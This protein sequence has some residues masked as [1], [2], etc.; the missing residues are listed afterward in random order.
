MKPGKREEKKLKEAQT[1]NKA[2]H[3]SKICRVPPVW[4]GGEDRKDSTA[5]FFFSRV[6]RVFRLNVGRLF[7][8]FFSS[9]DPPAQCRDRIRVITPPSET[10]D[11]RFF[12]FVQVR[13]SD[14]LLSPESGGNQ[15]TVFTHNN[16][17][18]DYTGL[19]VILFFRV[20]FYN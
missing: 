9:A 3:P 10:Q 17:V 7:P 20:V 8:F 6:I 1:L 4:R 12:V 13:L 19:R 15:G 5:R 18:Q 14:A 2:N 11:C 16:V